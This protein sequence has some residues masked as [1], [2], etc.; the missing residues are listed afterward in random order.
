MRHQWIRATTSVFLAA[1]PLVVGLV[2][3]H[4]EVIDIDG[5]VVA[6]SV[7]DR[8]ISIERQTAKGPKRVELEVARKSGN[9]FRSRMILRLR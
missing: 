1:L 7:D 4:A 2:A 8:T 6:V 3:L 5:T 9:A